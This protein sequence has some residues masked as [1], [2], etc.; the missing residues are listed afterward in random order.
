MLRTVKNVFSVLGRVGIDTHIWCVSVLLGAVLL[1]TSF[2][3]EPSHRQF[4]YVSEDAQSIARQIVIEYSSVLGGLS[5]LESLE[6]EEVEEIVEAIPEY[7]E[8]E[9][10]S[11]DMPKTEA[12]AV[13]YD[14]MIREETIDEFFEDIGDVSFVGK[15]EENVDISCIYPIEAVDALER[16][17]QS[18]AATEDEN[19]RKLVADVV[20]NRVDT[21]IWGDDIISVIESPGQFIPVS[22]GAYKNAVV[23]SVTKDAVLSALTGDDDSDGAI[24]FRKSAAKYWGDKEYLF[25]YGA[26]SFYK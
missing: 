10:V 12:L 3:V 6:D 24:Y 23:D 5:G 13:S 9:Q 14:D 1:C 19:G 18:E 4:V 25:R 20:L 21:G 16:L 26:H 22:N 8:K 15:K 11:E 7:E 2:F 17:V